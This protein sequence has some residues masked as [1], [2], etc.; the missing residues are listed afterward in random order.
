MD[1]DRSTGDSVADRERLRL[2]REGLQAA[3]EAADALCAGDIAPIKRWARESD[4]PRPTLA[5]GADIPAAI[6]GNAAMARSDERW[7]GDGGSVAFD[8]QL[9]GTMRKPPVRLVDLLTW[10]GELP[11][12]DRG[13]PLK[14]QIQ[15]E[16]LWPFLGHLVLLEAVDDNTDFRYRLYGSEVAK[17]AR[18][19]PTGRRL[20]SIAPRTPTF[21]IYRVTYAAAL[22]RAEPLFSDHHTQPYLAAERWQRLILPF[23]DPEDPSSVRYL[24]VGKIPVG[25]KVEAMADPGFVDW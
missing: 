6:A 17:I 15:P 22:R 24:L 25:F 7:V 16:A 5:W 14:G 21:F 11:R 20:S 1:G 19:D 12:D 3:R 10:Y 9:H 13:L 18:M 4:Y 2:W 8:P 23:A